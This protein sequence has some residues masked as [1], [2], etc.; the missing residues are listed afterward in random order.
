MLRVFLLGSCLFTC[1]APVRADLIVDG[2]FENPVV[3]DGQQ[4]S[5]SASFSGWTV[6]SD[7]VQF[8]NTNY[9]ESGIRFNAQSG[10]QSIDVSGYTNTMSDGIQQT[11]TTLIGEEYELSFYVGRAAFFDPGAATVDLSIDGGSRVHYTNANPAGGADINWE[12]F[13]VYFTATNNSTTLAFL[14]GTPIASGVVAG[15]RQRHPDRN[16]ARTLDS[17]DRISPAWHIR[18]CPVPRQSPENA[19]LPLG[20]CGLIRRG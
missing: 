6:I 16:S 13:I 3:P 5:V 10:N 19:P 1:A 14:N 18:R 20:D 17:R 9:V 11:V 2:S 4:Q 15:L 12:K 8:F 7:P